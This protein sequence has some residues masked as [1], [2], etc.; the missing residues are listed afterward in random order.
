MLRPSHSMCTYKYKQ[1]CLYVGDW[2][3]MWAFF[4]K[5]RHAT[6]IYRGNKVLSRKHCYR[7]QTISITYSECVFVTLVTRYAQCMPN[8]VICAL[9]RYTSMFSTF[10]KRYDF[11]K[12]KLLKTKCV[13]IFCTSAVFNIFHSMKNPARHHKR[14]SVCMY[15]T[16]IL[17]RL[18]LNL[19]TLDTFSITEFQDNPPSS[20][21]RAIPCEGADMTS[22]LSLFAV[23]RTSVKRY[24]F[25]ISPHPLPASVCHA[26]YVRNAS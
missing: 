6:Y 16:A 15:S 14:I 12:E 25:S 2:V 17:V 9:P 20:V 24:A 7:G 8:I 19:H 5:L 18:E 23:F 4:H 26:C 22:Y 3:K 11:R 1:Y 10:H 13:L 21:N